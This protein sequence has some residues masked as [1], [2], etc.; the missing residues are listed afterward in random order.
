MR[1]RQVELNEAARATSRTIR[2]GPARRARKAV[3]SRTEGPNSNKADR[4][5]SG[6]AL[7]ISPTIPTGP[8][9]P[10]RRAASTPTA[11]SSTPEVGTGGPDL[12]NAHE[13]LWRIE[14]TRRLDAA[15]EE[16]LRTSP[17]QARRP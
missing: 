15:E 12:F 4:R 17:E 1:S 6:A 7:A 2:S 14:S 8:A 13:L 5:A 11:A 9:R 16:T 10:V 3:S